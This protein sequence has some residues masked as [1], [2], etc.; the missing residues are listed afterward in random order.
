MTVD[1]VHSSDSDTE[2]A[3]HSTQD[4]SL[5]RIRTTNRI[6][7]KIL[8]LFLVPDVI[9]SE[10]VNEICFLFLVILTYSHREDIRQ[11]KS[12]PTPPPL[13]DITKPTGETTGSLRE[14]RRVIRCIS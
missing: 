5:P 3:T 8:P 10:N 13:L 2:T 4:R 14:T 6:D 12:I 1:T 9:D 7:P 11:I